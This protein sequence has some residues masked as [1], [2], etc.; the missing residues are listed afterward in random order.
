MTSGGQRMAILDLRVRAISEGRAHFGIRLNGCTL[1]FAY[2]RKNACTAFKEMILRESPH[3][4]GEGETPIAFLHRCHLLSKVQIEAADTRICVLRDP[5]DRMAS[6]YRNK[7]IQRQGHE[8]VFAS[9]RRVTGLDPEQARF[10][11]LANIYL[12]ASE[13]DMDPHFHSQISHL[14][15]IVYDRALRMGEI[16]GVMSDLLGSVTGAR[17]FAQRSNDSAGTAPFDD[18]S[19][20]VPADVLRDRYRRDGAMPSTRALLTDRTAGAVRSV[21]AA[22]H[23]LLDDLARSKKD[24]IVQ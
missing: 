2:I 7:F 24:E 1:A 8:E 11:D 14:A 12:A 19:D 17:Y 9:Y 23:G 3:S 21:Y 20:D 16:A 10:R 5:G 6:L 22:D 18:P 13:Q 4:R 15:P